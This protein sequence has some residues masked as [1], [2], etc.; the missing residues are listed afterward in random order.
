MFG[1]YEMAKV[2]SGLQLYTYT[3]VLVLIYLE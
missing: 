1:G 2:P 3:G